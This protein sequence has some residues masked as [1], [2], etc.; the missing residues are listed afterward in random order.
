MKYGFATPFASSQEK[1]DLPFYKAVKDAGYDF[2]ELPAT[3]INNINEDDYRRL[4]DYLGSIEFE[5]SGICSLFPGRIKFFDISGNE[6]EEYIDWIF[7]KVRPLGAQKIGFGSGGA[8]KLPEGMSPSEGMDI[9]TDKVRSHIVPYLDKYNYEMVIEAFNPKE[10]NFI[11]TAGEAVEAAAKIGSNRIGILTDTLHMIGSNDNADAVIANY[12][13]HIRHIH[14]SEPDRIFP[15][16]TY[17][18]ECLAC[19]NAFAKSGYDDTISFETSCRD[20]TDLAV[21]LA[22]LKRFFE[23]P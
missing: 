20:Y 12:Y 15:V 7:E 8:R 14:I 9:F 16:S 3:L 5:S 18:P 17:S 2:L 4:V 13:N 11:L 21:G 10:A 6:L 23:R 22:T 19:V 1:L